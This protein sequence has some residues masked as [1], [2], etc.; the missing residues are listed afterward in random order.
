MKFVTIFILISSL[1]AITQPVTLLVSLSMIG[2]LAT[3]TLN[4]VLDLGNTISTPSSSSLATN[5]CWKKQN[6]Q[7]YGTVWT[8][9]KYLLVMYTLIES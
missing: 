4:S 9:G 1:Y 3:S 5:N 8:T 7:Q 2:S 6:A